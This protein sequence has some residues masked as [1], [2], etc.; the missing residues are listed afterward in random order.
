MPLFIFCFLKRILP[1]RS[2]ISAI[3]TTFILSGLVACNNQSPSK[4]EIESDSTLFPAELVNFIPHKGN[5]VFSGGGK[6]AWDEVIR[7]RGYILKEKDGYHM[8]Y[9]GYRKDKHDTLFLGYASS[10]DGISWT[11]YAHNPIFKNSWTEDMMVVHADSLYYM[12]A[13]GKGD[14]A[15]MLTSSDKIH[16]N[17]YGPL[18]IQLRNGEPLSPGPY[19]TP[20]VL[21]E[22]NNWYLF[23]ERN[24]SAIWLASSKDLKVWRNVQDEPVINKGPELY[25]KFGVAL[26]QVIKYNGNYYGYYHGTALKDWSEWSTNVAVSKD[27]LH[28]E[29]YNKNPIMKENKSSGILVHDG[30]QYRLYTMHPEVCVHFSHEPK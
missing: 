4:K 6:E 17:D 2:V 20:T 29:K 16:W 9:T 8:W 5:P 12:F 21:K 13:E 28:W 19:G 30:S 7:E 10:P 1:M 18:Q 26:N 3:A 25:D 15:H 11:R 22:D 14:T 23:Y 24:D 27:L